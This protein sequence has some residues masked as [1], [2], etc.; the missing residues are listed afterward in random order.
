LQQAIRNDYKKDRDLLIAL[1]ILT[2]KEIENI[3]VNDPEH[4]NTTEI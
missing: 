2:K 3:D 1:D 4:Y